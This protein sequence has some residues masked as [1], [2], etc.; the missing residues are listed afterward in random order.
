MD[1]TRR[2]DIVAGRCAR[3]KKGRRYGTIKVENKVETVRLDQ[4]FFAYCGEP[5]RVSGARRQISAWP[6]QEPNAPCGLG[7]KL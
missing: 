2:D 4:G 6:G 7:V 3:E 5:Q 1:H